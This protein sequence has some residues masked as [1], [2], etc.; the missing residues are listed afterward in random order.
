MRTKENNCE[1]WGEIA[2]NGLTAN[3]CYWRHGD[4]DELKASPIERPQTRIMG[5]SDQLLSETHSPIDS[6]T[7]SKVKGKK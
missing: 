5:Y 6:E 2:K 3:C 1:K 7:S 4:Q